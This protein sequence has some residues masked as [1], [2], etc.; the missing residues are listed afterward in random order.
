MTVSGVTPP[1]HVGSRHPRSPHA[2]HGLPGGD[3]ILGP[4]GAIYAPSIPTPKATRETALTC[5]NW[6][7]WNWTA[8]AHAGINTHG[9][10]TARCL[11]Q[12]GATDKQ[13]TEF[14]Y[15]NIGHVPAVPQAPTI[16]TKGSFKCDGISTAQDRGNAICGVAMADS[17]AT[18]TGTC[19]YSNYGKPGYKPATI[20]YS[21]HLPKPA[22]PTPPTPPAPPA[23]PAKPPAKP[24][25]PK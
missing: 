12:N 23:P 15:P 16:K 21:C 18:V 14:G 6:C 24:P 3:Q 2:P 8:R 7:D 25:A 17:V 19:D 13:V 4:S 11:Y 22:P 20:Q 1:R 10:C 5:S 9:Q